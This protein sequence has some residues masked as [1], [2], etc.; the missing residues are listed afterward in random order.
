M[1]L[2]SKLES[3]SYDPI[4]V[5]KHRL[6]GTGVMMLNMDA[7]DMP[8]IAFKIVEEFGKNGLIPEKQKTQIL[9]TLLLNHSHVYEKT[10]FIF[11]GLR[12]SVSEVMTMNC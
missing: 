5:A 10:G 3:F 1:K 2:V 8:N 6:F 4:S 12:R 7:K 9:R 11:G